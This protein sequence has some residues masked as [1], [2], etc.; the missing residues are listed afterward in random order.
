MELKR[1]NGV[2]KKKYDQ[3]PYMRLYEESQNEALE[4]LTERNELTLD[5]IGIH[6][7]MIEQEEWERYQKQVKQI[8]TGVRT[9]RKERYK[10]SNKKKSCSHS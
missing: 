1:K 3:H 8:Y 5:K 2:G 4:C 7:D 10:E 6:A 9:L